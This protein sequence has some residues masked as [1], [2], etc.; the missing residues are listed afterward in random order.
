MVKSTTKDNKLNSLL[1]WIRKDIVFIIMATLTLAACFYTINSVDK[2]Q[3][4]INDAWFAQ[5]NQSC[6]CALQRHVPQIINISYN[7]KGNYNDVE[8]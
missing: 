7:I 8:N 6:P 3:D 5:W 2:Y 1:D 4:K